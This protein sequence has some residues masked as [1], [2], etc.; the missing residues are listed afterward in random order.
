MKLSTDDAVSM[1]CV[2]QRKERER[3]RQTDRRT[4]TLLRFGLR[5]M[6]QDQDYITAAAPEPY[7]GPGPLIIW[8]NILRQI[9]SR[10]LFE[11]T[12]L[13]EH[14]C[15]MLLEQCAFQM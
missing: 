15:F 5:F 10:V 7:H 9:C 2:R 3:E 1:S 11:C 6:V 13:Q 12:L 14:I 4:E 8:N